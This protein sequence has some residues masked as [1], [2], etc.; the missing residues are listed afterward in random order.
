LINELEEMFEIK[1][2]ISKEKWKV[3]FTANDGE[4]IEIVADPWL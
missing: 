4:T 3:A 2:L 1:G